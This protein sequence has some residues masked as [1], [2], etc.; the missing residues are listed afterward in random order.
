M[1]KSASKSKKD[2]QKNVYF[3]LRYILITTFD[4][5]YLYRVWN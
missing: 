1:L 3:E 2:L 4:R 5:S